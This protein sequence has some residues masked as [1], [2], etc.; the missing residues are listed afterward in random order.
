MNRKIFF[1]IL[2]VGILLFLFNCED[3]GDNSNNDLEFHG[4]YVVKYETGEITIDVNTENEQVNATLVPRESDSTQ[5]ELTGTYNS[6]SS[7]INISS[8]GY[9]F[10]GTILNENTLIGDIAKGTDTG[11]Y[12]TLEGD[13]VDNY[14]GIYTGDA[15]GNWNITIKDDIV[16]GTAYSFSG[17]HGDL[18]GL[19]SG[20]T[21]TGTFFDQYSETNIRGDWTGTFTLGSASGTWETDDDSDSGTFSGY[22]LGY[23]PSDGKITLEVINCVVDYDVYFAIAQEGIDINATDFDPATDYLGKNVFVILSGGSGDGT[24][25]GDDEVTEK[26]FTGGVIY[27]V[28]VFVDSDDNYVFETQ[29]GQ[30]TGDGYGSANNIIINGDQTV[31]LDWASDFTIIP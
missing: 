19:R 30:G 3:S 2:S 14:L 23:R 25:L 7:T 29:A 17:Y 16:T 1:I 24:A 6:S 21:I 11:S 4:T 26:L 27:T 12:A 28:Y 8:D 20:S 22:E 5:I 15:N 10:T 9:V 31:Q 18:D 13:N